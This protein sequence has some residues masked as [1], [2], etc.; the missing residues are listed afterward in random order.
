MIGADT[1]TLVLGKCLTTRSP[2][3]TSINLL[4]VATGSIVRS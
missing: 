3:S 2:Q 4:D 1:K